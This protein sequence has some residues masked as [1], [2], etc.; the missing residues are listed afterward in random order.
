[1]LNLNIN[2]I[3]QKPLNTDLLNKIFSCNESDCEMLTNNNS[4]NNNEEIVQ[5]KYIKSNDLVSINGYEHGKN[6]RNKVK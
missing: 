4:L 6:I 5:C 2:L 1:M 3:S